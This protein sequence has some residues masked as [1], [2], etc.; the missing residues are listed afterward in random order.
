MGLAASPGTDVLPTCSIADTIFPSSS[1]NLTRTPRNESFPSVKKS[2]VS[3]GRH[4]AA[5]D[6]VFRA[7]DGTGSR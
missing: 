2:S 6:H 3:R 7:G 4:G 1:E 5:V